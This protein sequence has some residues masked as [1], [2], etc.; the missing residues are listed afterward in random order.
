MDCS[1]NLRTVKTDSSSNLRTVK[2]QTAVTPYIP[3]CNLCRYIN[4]QKY[5][6]CCHFVTVA[7]AISALPKLGPY[8]LRGNSTLPSL[9]IVWF[10]P[11]CH[12]LTV[13]SA[14]SCLLAL[15]IPL[16]PVIYRRGKEWSR[17]SSK[18]KRKGK[19]PRG[20]ATWPSTRAV[21]WVTV[22]PDQLQK[23]VTL[24]LLLYG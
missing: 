18:V 16:L 5:C 12:L 2:T 13:G 20:R 4:I 11:P 24:L 6:F 1:S 14:T 10:F 8:D 7:Q 23:D 22:S 15:N 3:R 9:S 21:H 17:N 19:R